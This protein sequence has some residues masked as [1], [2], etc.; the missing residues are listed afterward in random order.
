MSQTG[1]R[2]LRT[3]LRL[4]A[5]E[6]Y[7]AASISRIAGELG[8][9]K[10]AMYRHFASKQALLE[11]ILARMERQDA[12]QAR[13]FEL[14]E[15]A[16]ESMR[17]AYERSGLGS[18]IAFSRAQFIYWTQDEFA[19]DFR[20][21]LTLSQFRSEEMG[22]LYQQYLGAGPLGYVRDLLAA[23]GLDDPD[24]RALELYGP[25]FLLMSVSDGMQE[26]AEALRQLDAHLC[27]QLKR[28]SMKEGE[29]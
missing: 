23:Q 24:A 29:K 17:E 28:L 11:A 27:R 9:S 2:I 10:A 6:G 18:L 19:T 1:E 8:L 20:R 21:M 26:K 7:E 25:M 16:P 5:S 4:F 3:A 14:P 22:R 15:G 13:A 12:E